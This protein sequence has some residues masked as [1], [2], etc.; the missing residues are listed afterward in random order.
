MK[1]K[2]GDTV[3]FNA[4]YA[5]QLWKRFCFS[6]AWNLS[7]PTIL[8]P[9]PVSTPG[10]GIIV[11]LRHVAMGY[12]LRPGQKD[13]E[14]GVAYRYC[15]EAESVMLIAY[16]IRRRPVYVRFCDLICE[17]EDSDD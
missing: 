9:Q 16:S 12:H 3:Q 13:R 6:K 8:A 15:S 17:K 5:T 11:G 10:T 1:Y 2:L 14:P 4:A 7:A